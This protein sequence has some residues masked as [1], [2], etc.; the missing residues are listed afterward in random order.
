MQSWVFCLSAWEGG[1]LRAEEE[2]HHC[3]CGAGLISH[4]CCLL[5]PGPWSRFSELKIS[6]L[7]GKRSMKSTSHSLIRQRMAA[8]EPVGRRVQ[9]KGLDNGG[10][11]FM[12]SMLLVGKRGVQSL[13]LVMTHKET[14]ILAHFH[15]MHSWIQIQQLRM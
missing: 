3:S 7:I 6:F 14:M 10:A 11:A 1:D 8:G 15:Q 12:D 9:R 13:V 2:A 4:F 5:G